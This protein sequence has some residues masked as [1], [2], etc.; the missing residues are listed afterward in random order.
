MLKIAN[1]DGS[2]ETLVDFVNRVWSEAYAGKM[3]FPH[4]T[5][6]FFEWQFRLDRD[7][8]RDNLIA[9]YD[10]PLVVGVLLGTRGMYRTPTGLLPGSQWS[11][12]SIAP[13]YQSRGI[14]KALDMERTRRQRE[15]R[16]RLIVSYR[17]VGSRHSLAERPRKGAENTKFNRKIGFWAR[18]L[19]PARFADW[20]W[21]PLEGLLAKAASL[22]SRIPPANPNVRSLNGSDLDA[23]LDLT[24]EFNVTLPLSMAWNRDSLFHQ[25]Y[26]N[27]ISQS[28]VIEEGGRISG[29][30]NF[31][32][33]PFQA[34]TTERV[35]IFDLIV[36]KAATTK[37]QIQ[38]LNAAILKMR[39]QG[40]ILALK[41]RCGD[42]PSW[43]LLRTHFIPQ[44][45][46]SYL[47][48]QGDQFSIPRSAPIHLLWR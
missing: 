2:V 44:P 22:I 24:R 21:S 7:E 16:S 38:L 25:L 17:Y 31:H 29:F 15:L 45:A 4:W 27:P 13:D 35:G 40:A 19:D 6:Q 32:L 5:S 8:S 37:G 11:W 47:V 30:V 23:C 20:H 12:L 46:D 43:P 41:L 10:G 42:S 1:Y 34:K 26:G 14:A 3:T 48:I 39:N 18:V 28:L 9:A 33:L 36:M